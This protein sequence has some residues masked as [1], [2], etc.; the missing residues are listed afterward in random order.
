MSRISENEEN[1]RQS[2]KLHHER[3][4]RLESGLTAGGQTPVEVIIQGDIFQR[5]SLSAL[6]FV[7]SMMPLNNILR[8]YTSWDY[9]FTRLQDKINLIL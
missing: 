6:P 1:I 9:K 8:T 5:D 4:E 7:R 2:R 3:H